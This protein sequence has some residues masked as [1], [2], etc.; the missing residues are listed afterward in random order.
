MRIFITLLLGALASLAAA[1]EREIYLLIGQSNMAGRAPIGA[2]QKEPI[3]RCELLDGEGQW[4]PA[5]NPLNRHSSI[6]KGLGMQK[7]NP[8]YSFA[9]KM[10]AADKT[11]SLGLVVNAKG[12]SSIG[13]WKKG[14]PF[15][16]DAVRRTKEAL[17]AGGTLAGILWHQGESDQNDADYLAKLKVLIADLR[18]D[19]GNE[20]LPFVAGQVS[21]VELINRQVAAL[22]AE[23]PQTAFASSRGLTCMDRWH[24]DPKSMK[25]LGERYADAILQLQKK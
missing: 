4:E 5:S 18:Q 3:A 10:L 25:L 7:V 17:Q 14:D 13:Q 11:R 22:P 15:Y 20:K 9:Q 23:V 19:F 21:K 6:R 1:G 24:F 16:N 2:E 8:G 12:G